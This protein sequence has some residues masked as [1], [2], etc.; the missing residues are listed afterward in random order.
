MTNKLKLYKYQ[1]KSFSSVLQ[2]KEINPITKGLS[3]TIKTFPQISDSVLILNEDRL[4]FLIHEQ[5]MQ[6]LNLSSVYIHKLKIYSESIYVYIKLINIHHIR[7]HF[8][9]RIGKKSESAL[10][11]EEAHTTFMSYNT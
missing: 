7:C 5:Q 9:N 2:A 4:I 8:P 6:I 10:F 11:N 3:T 1:A